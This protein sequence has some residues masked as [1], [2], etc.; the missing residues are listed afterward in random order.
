MPSWF[1]IQAILLKIQI[2]FAEN[3]S[4]KMLRISAIILF[5]S[6]TLVRVEAQTPRDSIITVPG[7]DSFA[8]PID[9]TFNNDEDENT[10]PEKISKEQTAYESAEIKQHNFDKDKWHNLTKDLDYSIEKKKIEEKKQSTSWL[11][12]DQ[13][14][15]LIELFKAIFWILAIGLVLFLVYKIVDNGGIFF[16]KSRKVNML[17]DATTIHIDEEDIQNNDFDALINRALSQKN[18]ILAVR[19]YYMA[20]LKELDA[21]RKIKWEKEKTNSRYITEM[22]SHPLSEAF[23]RCTR[24]FDTYFYGQRVLDENVFS[25]IQPEFKTLLEQCKPIEPELA[26]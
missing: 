13:I 21:T 12:P 4:F 3:K 19:L 22:Q 7:V 14:K 1:K 20:I 18:Y 16:R 25:N 23:N 17:D 26:K 8:N 15:V 5:L 11:G 6:F 9:T 2:I 24:L 10:T